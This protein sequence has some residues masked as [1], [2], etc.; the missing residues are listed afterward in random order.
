MAGSGKV[1]SGEFKK[2]GILHH[3]KLPEARALARQLAK[4]LQ[5]PQVSV[6]TCSSSE[7]KEAAIKAIDSDLILSVG[8]DGT[9]L[10]AV[11]VTLDKVIPILGVNMGRLGFMTELSAEDALQKMPFLLSQSS[12]MD[13]RS[14]L[15]AKVILS[16]DQTETSAPLYALN[17]VVVA[18]GRVARVIRVETRI[19]KDLFTTYRADGVIVASAT[20]STSYSMAVGG[21]ILYPQSK[22]IILIPVAPHL[23][24]RNPLVLPPSAEVQLTIHS[25]HRPLLSV[26]GQVHRELRDGDQVMISLSPKVTRF[27]RFQPP[28]RF[29][30]TVTQR[31]TRME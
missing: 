14:V 1:Q 17:D 21:P 15:Q 29:Y 4:K 2:I 6:W 31:L 24:L 3:S 27:L 28:G 25:D 12:W 23:T 7:E 26:D 30:S 20:G 8:G 13:D 5:G 10:S 19:D 16:G 22:E 9:I 11:R 18:R